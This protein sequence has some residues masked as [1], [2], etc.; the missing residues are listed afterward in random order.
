MVLVALLVAGC[1][2]EEFPDP[3]GLVDRAFAREALLDGPVGPA[4]VE[5][6]NLGFGDRILEAR[7]VP[8]D[9]PTHREILR[10]LSSD[11]SGEGAATGLVSLAGGLETGEGGEVGGVE[12]YPV[13]GMIETGDLVDAVEGAG[14]D[15]GE[16]LGVEDVKS[17]RQGLESV[18]FTAWVSKDEE[19]LERLDLVLALDDP[20]NSLPPSRIR[21]RLD[22]RNARAVGQD[23]ER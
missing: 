7:I 20:G 4:S 19:K 1:S 18:E 13:S 3:R 5:V 16:D 2:G 9:A 12:A 8:V 17:L 10:L 15:V 11:S 21:F 6:A 22:D 23:V 14:A